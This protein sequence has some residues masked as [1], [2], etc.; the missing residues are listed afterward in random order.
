MILLLLIEQSDW[1]NYRT[2]SAV[3]V[4]RLRSLVFLSQIPLVAGPLYFSVVPTDREPGAGCS[5]DGFLVRYQ[6][7]FPQTY[8][9]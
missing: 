7:Q 9:M 8:Q 4:Q 3:S 6:T 5:K 1:L 2:L